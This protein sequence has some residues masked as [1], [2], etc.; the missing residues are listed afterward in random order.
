MYTELHE[1]VLKQYVSFR[2]NSQAQNQSLC[3]LSRL[4][5]HK[6]SMVEELDKVWESNIHE[7]IKKSEVRLGHSILRSVWLHRYKTTPDGDMYCHILR[8][9]ADGGTQ[10]FGL[11]YNENY[12]PVIMWSILRT[13]FILW[14]SLRSKSRKVDYIQVF[15]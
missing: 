4:I 3:I 5:L 2:S 11:D 12:S 7:I 6:I 1:Y 9:C 8:L 15:P 14:K 10:K 13:L